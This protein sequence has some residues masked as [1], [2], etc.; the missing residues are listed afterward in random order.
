M[1]DSPPEPMKIGAIDPG[2]HQLRR[3][4]RRQGQSGWVLGAS[5]HTREQRPGTGHTQRNAKLR[6]EP[7]PK[8]GHSQ[9][10]YFSRFSEPS[11]C[12]HRRGGRAGLAPKLP[13]ETAMANSPPEP[14]KTGAIDGGAHPVSCAADPG[15]PQ[16]PLDPPPHP[17]P[18]ASR[19][20]REQRPG[21]GHTQRNAKL[22]KE[23]SPKI[24]HSQVRHMRRF[25]EQPSPKIGHSRRTYQNF[26]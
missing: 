10:R 18:G 15:E 5:R 11:S 21:T 20:I 14:M 3:N 1:A 16:A 22:R 12:N 17:V 8:I 26:R 7:S 6:K 19:H 4:R 2:A 23:P 9:V 25:S 24:G 13:T